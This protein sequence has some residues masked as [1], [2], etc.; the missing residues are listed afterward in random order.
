MHMIT[1]NE[2]KPLVKNVVGDKAKEIISKDEKFI[3]TT[4]KASPAVVKEAKGIVFE[5][6]DGNIFFDFTSGGGA[7]GGSGATG[8]TNVSSSGISSTSSLWTSLN[9]L[10]TCVNPRLFPHSHTYGFFTKFSSC[11]TVVLA[12]QAGQEK[13]MKII[14]GL[15]SDA[16][17]IIPSND[18][19]LF[20]WVLLKS[21][22]APYEQAEN[23]NH[24]PN[25]ARKLL[26][27]RREINRLM[28]KVREKGLTIIPLKLYFN[29]RGFAKLQIALARG[30]ATHD[31]RQQI[32][33]RDMDR[34]IARETRKY[35]R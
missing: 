3:A 32:R 1:G 2:S 21:F 9:F 13:V 23:Q 10:I 29:D 15:T 19:N 30:K 14:S 16:C 24:D 34:Q 22:I 11:I 20:M 31:K 5:D 6:V 17:F 28:G 25:R 7:G 26:L 4:T 18:M 35:K 12:P 8:G 33:K 27:H